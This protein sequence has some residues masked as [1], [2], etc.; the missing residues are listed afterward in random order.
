MVDPMKINHCYIVEVIWIFPAVLDMWWIMG[1]RSLFN[2]SWQ[3]AATATT[4][5]K[6]KKKGG[7]GKKKER[8]K[9]KEG[10]NIFCLSN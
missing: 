2:V 5:T 1:I 7:G 6:N 4:T 8:R 3:K 9:N 10:E